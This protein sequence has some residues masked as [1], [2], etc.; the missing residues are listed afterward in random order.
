[1]SGLPVTLLVVA[2]APEPGRVKTRLAAA[3]GDRL[4]ADIAAAALLDTLDAAAATPVAARVLALTGDLD[5]AARAAEIRQRVESFT[6]IEQRGDDFADRLANAHIDSADQAGGHP[7]LQ[8]GMDTPQVTAEL[9]A[10]CACRLL[11]TPA[12]LGLAHDGG[13]WVLGVQTSAMAECLRAVPM[14]QPDTGELT[15]K[16]LHSNAIDVTSVDPLA[17]FDFVDDIAAVRD[18]CA[19]ASRF[20]R[21]TRAAGL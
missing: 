19:P 7:V 13:W 8:I 2:K 20:A 5:T 18:A 3:V 9:L 15:L 6:V 11:N 10:N 21:A 12:V 14:S 17:D 16:A 4:A 1:M